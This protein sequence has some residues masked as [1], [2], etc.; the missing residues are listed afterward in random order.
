APIRAR[1]QSDTAKT[2]FWQLG[3]G[4][5]RNVIGDE[6]IERIRYIHKNPITRGLSPDSVSWKWSS[7]AAYRQLPQAIGPLIAFDLVPRHAQELT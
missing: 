3:G 2:H 7:A 5:D 6:L 4:Y 1:L